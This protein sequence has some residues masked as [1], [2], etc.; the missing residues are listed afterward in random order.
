MNKAFR[1]VEKKV[2][3]GKQ[4]S[5]L[6]MF[7]KVAGPIRPSQQQQ[8]Q[9]P[10]PAEQA[11]V[12]QI[13]SDSDSDGASEESA[14]TTPAAASESVPTEV[15][16]ALQQLPTPPQT[17]RYSAEQKQGAL[18][19]T[20]DALPSTWPA[21]AYVMLCTLFAAAYVMS[22][23][24]IVHTHV[25]KSGGG[26][27]AHF[28]KPKKRVGHHSVRAQKLTKKSPHGLNYR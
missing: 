2:E 27:G 3:Q 23:S 19:L 8:Q 22:C 20:M 7:R 21:T 10:A 12:V 6:D 26:G 13:D 25:R 1:E 11:V 4:R 16:A 24:Q 9:R 17:H 18:M 5:M 28:H 15:A 14:A